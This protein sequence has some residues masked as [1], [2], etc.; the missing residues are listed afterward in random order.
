MELECQR[1]GIELTKHTGDFKFRAQVVG[2]Q[3]HAG[4]RTESRRKAEVEEDRH[5]IPATVLQQLVLDDQ[6]VDEV[7][8]SKIRTI[9]VCMDFRTDD[10]LSP[11]YT[12]LEFRRS[13][14]P[15]SIVDVDDLA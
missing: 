6:L 7:K 3:K 4:Q 13:T 5:W 11:T 14:R 15:E 10:G 8:L 12:P 9:G 2:R 1:L